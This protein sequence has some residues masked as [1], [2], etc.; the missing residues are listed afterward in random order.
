MY[1]LPHAGIISQQLLEK[2]LA[3]HGYRRSKTTPGFWTHDWRP[4]CFSLIVNDFGVKYVGREHAEHLLGVLRKN[5][6]VTDDWTES[7]K[8]AGILLD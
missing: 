8:Y 1:G 2:R 3:K 5:Y 6:E 4:I 7:Q